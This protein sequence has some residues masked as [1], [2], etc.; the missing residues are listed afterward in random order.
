MLRPFLLFVY[1]AKIFVFIQKIEGTTEYDTY[2]HVFSKQNINKPI[3][4]LW[5]DTTKWLKERSLQNCSI[6]LIAHGYAE[7]WNMDWR[8]DW[9]NE[10]KNEIINNKMNENLCVIAIDWEQGAR[11]INFITAVSNADIA[12]QHLAEFIQNNL[13]DPKRLHCIGFSLGAHL[14]AFASNNYYT[15]SN[16]KLRFARISGLDPSGPLLRKASID[17]RLSS[18]DADFVDCIHTST[19]FGLQEKSGHMDFFPDG[20]KSSAQGCEKFIKIEDND[21]T[22]N[23]FRI[24]RFLYSRNRK[25]NDTSEDMPKKS[26]LGKI[27]D[28]LGALTPLKKVF[29]NIHAYIG[30][31]HLRSPHYFISSINQCNFRAKLCSS[32]TD[33]LSKKCKDPV[34]NDLTY[35]R[36]GFYA[37]KS[38]PIYKVGNG[39]YYLKTT[40]DKPYCALS[41]SSR[42][43]KESKKQTS[44]KSK[45]KKKLSK[46]LPKKIG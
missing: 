3:T 32:W 13:I 37:D 33:Y 14:C 6:K 11:E 5:A 12:G 31:N 8:W 10:M 44:L 42:S 40:P 19:T 36:M 45:L 24:K 17:K 29:L 23:R 27:R 39:D 25:E 28:R 43:E 20:G 34:D 7:R 30:C 2:F 16:K 21:E 46:V 26:I 38:N 1:I 18:D 41:L 35:P 9:V 4:I 15:I 22:E